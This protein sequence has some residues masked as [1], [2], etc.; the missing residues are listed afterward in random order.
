MQ[1]RPFSRS[2]GSI[3]PSSLA[4]NLSSALE[5]SS[6]PPVSVYGTGRT[7]RFSWQLI[8]WIIALAEASAYYRGIT[9]PFNAAFHRRAPS[10]HLR[11][12]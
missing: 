5:Y 6:R 7:S 12:F 8:S 3:L 4:M 10:T 1:G 2:Y 9:T 11:R